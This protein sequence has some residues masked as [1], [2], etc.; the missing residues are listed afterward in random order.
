MGQRT[1]DEKRFS[2]FCGQITEE[3]FTTSANQFFTLDS[4]EPILKQ[5]SKTMPGV[6]KY[7]N[8]QFSQ[9]SYVFQRKKQMTKRSKGDSFSQDMPPTILL[10]NKAQNSI[11]QKLLSKDRT[12]NFLFA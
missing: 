2:T 10:T 7:R 9:V 5:V 12:K 3:V 1:I 8:K 4:P 11:I 6:F